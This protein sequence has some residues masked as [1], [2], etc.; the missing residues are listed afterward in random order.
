VADMYIIIVG[1][2]KLGYYL[3]KTLAPEK[4]KLVLIEED[5]KL[6]RKIVDELS[7][8]GVQVIHG[9]GTDINSLKDASIGQA[10]ILIAVTGFDENNLVA[11]QL[12]KNYFDVARTIARVNNPKNINVFKQ[13]GVDSVVSSTALIAD[14]IELEV[15]WACLNNMF[16]RHVGNVRI[17]EIHVDRHAR[18][19]GKK[20][21][22][23]RLP[24]GTIII[25]LI[26]DNQ[27]II[28]DGQM[29][30][31]AGDN[32]VTLTHADNLASL[33]GYFQ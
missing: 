33:S 21:V 18:S 3:A 14:I 13:L 30:I 19:V 22:D 16:A 27:V 4:H 28:P 32:V 17:K 25:S 23:L 26:R 6:C 29:N 11:C 5:L 15:D 31:L 2:G 8:L 20:I 7:V 24:D 1:G 9:D 10:D 12:A